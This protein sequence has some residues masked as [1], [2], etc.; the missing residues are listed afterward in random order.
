MNGQENYILEE[1]DGEFI[2]SNLLQLENKIV[3]HIANVDTGF[4][5]VASKDY[6]NCLDV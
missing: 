4:Y 3:W 6:D 1:K 2:Q 5:F